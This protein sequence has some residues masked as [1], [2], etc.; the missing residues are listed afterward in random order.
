[1]D[2]PPPDDMS[3]V[4]PYTHDLNSEISYAINAALNNC[5]RDY[6]CSLCPRVASRR[7]EL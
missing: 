4:A 2:I 7:D 1:M 6:V 5:I 3:V